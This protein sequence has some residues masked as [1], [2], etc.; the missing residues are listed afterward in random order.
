[1]NPSFFEDKIFS[2]SEVCTIL[3]SFIRESLSDIRIE[4][5]ISNFKTNSSG[6]WYLSLK[7]K[8]G[9]MINCAVFKSMNYRMRKPE[10]GDYVTVQGSFNF[11]D[12]GGSLTFIIRSMKKKGE[13]DLQAEI[14]KRRQ[15]YQELGY[16]DQENKK[17]LP[18]LINRIAVITSPAGAVINDILRVTLRRAPGVDIVI[19]P[20]PVQ[21]ENAASIISSRIRQA[22]NF[23]LADVIILARGGG[24]KE[25]LAPYSE[26]AVIEAIHSSAIPV[27]SAVGHDSD[28]PLSDFVSDIRAS[29]PSVAAELVTQSVFN[30]RE[31][32]KSILSQ[33]A[34]LM[35]RRLREAERRVNDLKY[36]S[37]RIKKKAERAK[38]A[39]L[40]FNTAER[41]LEARIY[42][43]R[44][45]LNF[46]SDNLVKSMLRILDESK[47]EKE[48]LSGGISLMIENLL[49][50]KKRK[51]EKLCELTDALSPYEILKRGYTIA[52][53]RDGKIIR[54][55]K[56][57]S[58]DMI[59]QF[60][61][62]NIE[63][64]KKT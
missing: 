41:S 26:S 61:D 30:A 7:D 47:R 17:S 57:A 48:R 16:F 50:A 2:V 20:S 49:T 34:L 8:D 5:E 54:S 44:M 36:D 46:S 59:I 39:L 23:M 62:G 40:S 24:S 35:N 53:D 1:M 18:A 64:R 9:S 31:R 14:E 27:V 11:W 32:H 19:L 63:V 28:F 12:K 52:R 42:S 25:D 55:S 45:S 15:Y 58:D 22:N 4:G 37:L 38:L 21:G 51:L 10:N 56:N 60:A 6:H 33:I 29:T 43:A 3:S 13:G